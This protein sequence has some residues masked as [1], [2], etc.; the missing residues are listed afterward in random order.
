MPDADGAVA[1][2]RAEAT[3]GDRLGRRTKREDPYDQ[4][5][6]LGHRRQCLQCAELGGGVTLLTFQG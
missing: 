4:E 5:R 3:L 2:D 6:F 1:H